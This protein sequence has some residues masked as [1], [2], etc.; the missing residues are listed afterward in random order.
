MKRPKRFL[1]LIL[2]L[3]VINTVF[4]IAWYGFD[5]QNVVKN[6]AANELAKAMKGSASIQEL[7]FSERQIFVK[8]ISFKARDGS[9][10][11][12][13]EHIRVRYNLLKFLISGFRIRNGLDQVEIESPYFRYTYRGP[14][15]GPKLYKYHPPFQIPDLSR[16]F[17]EI[18]VQNGRARGEIVLGLKILTADSLRIAEELHD[19]SIVAINKRN[20][21]L[22]VRANSSG[23]G[24]VKAD[25]LLQKGRLIEGSAELSSFSPIY[26]YHPD[27]N[28]FN[29][30]LNLAVNAR[31]AHAKAPVTF[32][33]Q[34]FLWN[35]QA[36]FLDKYPVSIPF[37]SGFT[38]GKKLSAEI[39]QSTI[40]TSK[41]EGSAVLNE[42][43]G[44][45]SIDGSLRFDGIDL[46]MLELGLEGMVEADLV[47][48]GDL[49]DPVAELQLGSG[50]VRYSGMELRDLL[51]KADYAEHKANFEISN[52]S[53]GNQD[54]R[55][56]GSFDTR[57]LALDAK[58][59]TSARQSFGQPLTAS[60][61][62]SLQA[63]FMNKYPAAELFLKDIDFSYQLLELTGLNGAVNLVPLGESYIARAELTGDQGFALEAVGD[64]IKREGVLDA[65]FAGVRA[66]DIYAQQ[67]LLDL[68]PTIS[69]RLKA[70]LDGDRVTLNAALSTA[71]GLDQQF[72][73]STDLGILGSYDLR[74]GDATINLETSNGIL[75]GQ[76]LEL[77]LAAA[78]QDERVKVYGLRLNQ[79][80]SLSGDIDL[81]RREDLNFDL[82]VR[83]LSSDLI[84][85]YLPEQ[86]LNLPEISGLSLTA[87][88]DHDFADDLSI[89]LNL[90]KFEV[91]GLYPLSSELSISGN[92]Q[93]CMITGAVS[94]LRG[95]LIRISGDAS[96]GSK[97]SLN[98]KARLEDLQP[99]DLIWNPPVSA[100][101]T[102][103]VAVEYTD[104]FK[105][106][107][108][109]LIGLDMHLRDF[110]MDG[111]AADYAD[112]VVQQKKD[113]L[114]VDVLSAGKADLFTLTGSGAVDYNILENRFTE[115]D[116]KL[117]LG[118]SGELFPWLDR[119]LDYIT[120]ASGKSTLIAEI[121]TAEEQFLIRTGKLEIVDGRVELQDQ[122]EA[123]QDINIDASFDNNRFIINTA[124]MKMGKGK[125]NL[126]NHFQE[127]VSDHFQ[128][129][130]LDL[131]IFELSISEPGALINVPLFTPPRSLANI[132]LKGQRGAT[133]TVM[134]PFDDM[135]ISAEATVSNA[136]AVYPPNT[137]DLLK[138]IYSV[139]D[140]A[141]KKPVT[142]AAPLPFRL[143]LILHLEENVRYV[144]Y[145]TS[146]KIDPG[147]YLHLIY[148]GL[149]WRLSEAKFS[150][151][152]GSIDFFGTVF[153]A[154]ALNITILEARE[155]LLI[156][157]S[158][159][160]RAPDGSTITLGI[161]TDRDT[162]KGFFNRLQF[163]LSSDNPDDRSITD[164]LARL[165]YNT[166]ADELS[167][168]QKQNLLSDEAINLIGGNLNSSLLSPMLYPLENSMRRFLKLDVFTI[169]VGFI[170]NLF[171]E[172][173]SD[174]GQL[175]GYA[176]M[177]QINTDIMRFSSS[178]LLNNLSVSM[179]KYLVGKLFLD[180]KF[181]LQEATDLQKNTVMLVAH[182]TSLRMMLP[183]KLRIAYNLKYE[184]AKTRFTHG[185]MLNRSFRF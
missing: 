12:R 72:A 151:E 155:V 161:N 35:T 21:T 87:K 16:Y 164:I 167:G 31:Q 58:L 68:D 62:L 128:I 45:T 99:S 118:V 4:F 172:Y 78:K 173:T 86:E 105:E 147:S 159:V 37:A 152:S 11:F 177:K 112:L 146:I 44:S 153:E 157:G 96:I 75:N 182:D 28:D 122:A 123:V 39:A 176:D 70:F 83:D 24:A 143:D 108:S 115:G 162:S 106:L 101:L 79:L 127:D 57:L 56:S 120:K 178:I 124:N 160:K 89:K 165:R 94:N 121:G 141:T 116:H 114:L 64:L 117:H 144:T 26:A 137:D 184:P 67:S 13:V 69:G 84:Q 52:G 109:P 166:Q 30:E 138:L 92:P 175:A 149:T 133:A 32:D 174:P 111:F 1:I 65:Q 81:K 9:M 95:N 63:D 33:A 48:S 46:S 20:T 47:A 29:T 91:P 42:L 71:L 41:V 40:G 148:D 25:L 129:A 6:I 97:I 131:G 17:N 181:T 82:A 8:G 27:I 14:K 156:E 104:L 171:T 88:Y 134:G 55:G 23:N 168:A 169:N 142:E 49:K 113:I 34:A 158:F 132:S 119:S 3:L 130:F 145:P 136:S 51:L 43:F 2:I 140:V 36:R 103:S 126:S 185:V 135:K 15:S 90:G 125:I 19:I 180:Y 93:N 22:R 154:E 100:K 76:N 60:G 85:S 74:S 66:A 110:S 59:Q 50:S 7:K 61:E 107:S 18:R 170:Q 183:L 179:S 10:D 150:S 102:G 80:L 38:D 73:L 77:S 139:R 54:L 53:L 5:L 163:R 98:T